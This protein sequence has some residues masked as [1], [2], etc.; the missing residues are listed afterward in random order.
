MIELIEVSKAFG[1][2]VVLERVS[3]RVEEGETLGLFGPSG[4][5]KSVTLKH[6]IG[7]IEPDEGDVIVDGISIPNAGRSELT[8]VRRRVGY[9]FQGSALFDS[10]DVCENILLGM[11]EEMVRQDR[12]AAL[13]RVE[14]CLR[15][16]NLEPEVAHL[17]PSELSGGMQKRVAMARAIAGH[18]RYLLYD[19]PTTGLDP[20]NAT[21]ITNLIA[22]L[23]EEIGVTGIM[24]THDLENAFRVCDR[25]ALLYEARIHALGTVQEFI[26]SDDP[27]VQSF[28]NPD[29]ES[30][31]V[32]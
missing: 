4:T 21:I 12:A 7:L 18:Q 11:P 27:I 3:F 26:E 5:G 16:V 10:M 2:N 20:K 19:E 28:V 1:N 25:V 23:N 15:L 31:Q 29:P 30:I 14:E 9:V 6:I 8:A 24:V 22:H 17:Y 32:A 13:E